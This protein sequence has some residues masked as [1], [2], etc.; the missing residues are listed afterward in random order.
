MHRIAVQ[1]VVAAGVLALV[2]ACSATNAGVDAES[3]T[4]TSLSPALSISSGMQ[5]SDES[6]GG[7]SEAARMI[8]SPDV[9]RGISTSLAT[10]VAPGS[11]TWANLVYTCRYQLATGPLVL[12]VKDSPNESAGLSYFTHARTRA[13][14]ARPLLGLL[15]LGLPS[16]ETPAGTAV[17]LKD[18]K[19]L[20]VDASRLPMHIG[21]D[22]RSR[23][24]VA[25]AVA[26]LVVAC[27]SE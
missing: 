19:T 18:G 3:R 27:W 8:C 14:A 11:A 17:F 4:S 25:Y 21:P 22:P 12:S 16:Y 26:A 7:P 15:N 6:G 1:H 23:T 24:D 2:S 20:I 13:T 9:R 5:M 10:S